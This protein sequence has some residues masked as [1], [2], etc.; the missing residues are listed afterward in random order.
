MFVVGCFVLVCVGGSVATDHIKCR[1]RGST[2]ILLRTSFI[3]PP[4]E[5]AA[6]TT[7]SPS[8]RPL[9]DVRRPRHPHAVP[10]MAG[11]HAAA[12]LAAAAREQVSGRRCGS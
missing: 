1:Q 4:A 3:E 9:R 7:R 2:K 10:R 5:P 6:L 11:A 12:E 8:S